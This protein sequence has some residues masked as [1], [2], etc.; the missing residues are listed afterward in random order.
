MK[1]IKKAKD[2]DK[3]RLTE[4]MRISWR[5]L[6]EY[7]PSTQVKTNSPGLLGSNNHTGKI[8]S[9][10]ETKMVKNFMVIMMTEA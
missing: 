3:V 6:N 10:T 9:H 2:L 1:R 4:S 8:M 5:P 7:I